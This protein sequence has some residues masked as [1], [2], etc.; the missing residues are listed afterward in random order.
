MKAELERV[1]AEVSRAAEY[2]SVT[3]LQAQTGQ[4]QR[5]FAAVVLKEL[6]DNAL[7]AAEAAR[8]SPRVDIR[9]VRGDPL[10][11]AVRDNGPG[12]EPGVLRRVLDFGVRV[13]D[14]VVYRAPTRGLQGNALKTVLGIPF[15]L[16]CA[17]PVVVEACGVRHLI[18]VRADPVGRVKVEHVEEACDLAEGTLVE[19]P[20]PAAGQV[21]SLLGW[22]RAFAVFNPHAWLK[23]RV[24]DGGGSLRSAC[25]P[26]GAAREEFHEPTVEFPGGWRKFLPRDLT[27]PHWYDLESFA[28]LVFAH[29]R[30]IEEERSRDVTLREFVRQF[31]GLTA[32]GRASAVCDAVPGIRH[33]SDFEGRPEAVE[34]L[35]RAMCEHAPAPSPEVLGCCG[36]GHFRALFRRWYGDGGRFWYRRATGCAGGVPYVVEA[37]LAE[38]R[39]EG[40]KVFA[41]INFSPA[42]GDPL[43]GTLLPGPK[44]SAYGVQGFVSEALEPGRQWRLGGVAVAFHMVCPVVAFLDRAKA[45]L[46]VPEQ[47]ARDAAGALWAVCGTLH[48]EGERYRRRAVRWEKEARAGQKVGRGWTLKEAV[49]AVLEDAVEKATG[50]G[51]YPVSARTLYYQVRALIQEHT[52]GE[53]DY[54]Y[55]SQ[56]LLLEYQERFGE[57]KGLY[58]DP[59]GHLYEPHTNVVVPLGTREVGAYDFPEWVF[60]KVLYVEKKGLWPVL[61]AAR[62]GERYDMAIVAAEG[63]A[64]E[65]ARVLF[66][67]AERDRECRLFVLHDADPYGYNIARTLREQTRRMRGYHVDV[68]DIGLRLDEAL[69]MGLQVEEFTRQQALP[70]GVEETLSQVEREYFVG[71]KEGK[72]WVCRRVELNAMT[73]PQLVGYVEAKLA[74]CGAAGK[75][76]PP[77]EVVAAEAEAAYLRDLEALAE[78]QVAELLNVPGLVRR[79]LELAGRP[80]FGSLHAGLSGVLACMP[81]QSWREMVRKWM[82][83]EAGR[84]LE[85]V[86]WARVLGSAGRGPGDA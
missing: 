80:D 15:A 78:R 77:P 76:L 40:E 32:A 28:R 6:V 22:A 36:E 5:L 43:A 27:S 2:V 83:E 62:L 35:F 39:A 50:G 66:Q 55:F 46:H 42:Y 85:R 44:L 8:V 63:Y 30:A 84:A 47:V 81:A 45:R 21:L 69:A 49:F 13:S 67:R 34:L 79:A 48:R 58:Y 71:R 7:D 86:D 19:V 25:S 41:G 60:D 72:V 57:I 3:E 11:V 68:I 52:S 61:E 4:P 56:Q 65:A 23:I 53:L 18:R 54:N 24:A 14:K 16:G 59:R 37:A 74:E 20:V 9:V 17:E 38:T 12:L 10:L 26:A 64:T 82:R 73:G 75:V 31:R 51:R 29:V 33:I 1:V 70:Q